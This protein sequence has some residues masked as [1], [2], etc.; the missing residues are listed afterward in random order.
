ML[1]ASKSRALSA[2]Q[3]RPKGVWFIGFWNTR[4]SMVSRYVVCKG[5]GIARGTRLFVW[6][7]SPPEKARPSPAPWRFFTQQ[8]AFYTITSV[9]LLYGLDAPLSII[10]PPALLPGKNLFGLLVFIKSSILY[11]RYDLL[12][13]FIRK[14]KRNAQRN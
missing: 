9:L 7:Y 5:R 12:I 11:N 14:D 13:I 10:E 8:E 1:L 4:Q 6:A 2:H 3:K